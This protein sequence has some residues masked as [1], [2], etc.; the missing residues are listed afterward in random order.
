MSSY[1]ITRPHRHTVQYENEDSTVEFEV[2]SAINGII[3]YKKSGTLI[4]GN[5]QDF[6]SMANQVELW[7]K[8]KYSYVDVVDN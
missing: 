7:L 5:Q 8:D 3:F 6:R 1:K 2:E 4:N